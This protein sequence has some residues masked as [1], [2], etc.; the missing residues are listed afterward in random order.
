[1]LQP[2]IVLQSRGKG[3][4]EKLIFERLRDRK[5]NRDP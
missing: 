3:E 5:N 1:M 2:H 4:L